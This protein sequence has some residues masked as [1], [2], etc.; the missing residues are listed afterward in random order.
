MMQTILTVI[1]GTGGTQVPRTGVPNTSEEEFGVLFGDDDGPDSLA[2]PILDTAGTADF[3][4]DGATG[5]ALWILPPDEVTLAA[6]E[7]ATRDEADQFVV[8]D[9][10]GVIAA[11][12]PIPEHFSVGMPGF[13]LQPDLNTNPL[14]AESQLAARLIDVRSGTST[15]TTPGAATAEGRAPVTVQTD[16]IDRAEDLARASSPNSPPALK[17]DVQTKV[18]I[19]GDI[20]YPG[21][22]P[23]ADGDLVPVVSASR[24]TSLRRASSAAMFSPERTAVADG[25]Q[26]DATAKVAKTAPF[27]PDMPKA[28][29]N[30]FIDFNATEGEE[31]TG[32]VK[33]PSQPVSLWEA[34]FPAE[35]F[36]EATRRARVGVPAPASVFGLADVAALAAAKGAISKMTIPS[37]IAEAPTPGNLKPEVAETTTM[38]AMI[39]KERTGV[40]EAKR[41]MTAFNLTDLLA[42]D[43]SDFSVADLPDSVALIV[44]GNGQ[45]GQSVSQTTA[46][47]LGAAVQHLGAQLVAGLSSPK[48][49]VTEISLSPEELGTVKLRLQTDTQNPDRMVVMLSFDRPETMDLFRRN[50]DQLAEVIRSAG[51]SGVDIGFAQHGQDGRPQ[52]GKT[53]NPEAVQ[54]ALPDVETLDSPVSQRR[55]HLAGSGLDLRL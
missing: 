21:S 24:E 31:S 11:P 9:A 48:P 20:S 28:G 7:I 43:M 23:E 25:V 49:G 27:D 38:L 12:V 2:L 18:R 54:A 16:D 29:T 32:L 50:A 8:P 30:E 6:A 26:D 1:F 14:P 10:S 41:P 46:P 19:D 47:L 37:P 35:T 51:Y 4:T 40:A 42:L 53:A 13:S 44:S 17:G 5:A 33:V 36:A 39:P 22:E 34:V 15:D 3:R 52:A 45:I 55:P